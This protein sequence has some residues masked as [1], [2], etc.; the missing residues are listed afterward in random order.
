[1]HSDILEINIKYEDIKHL[2][3]LKINLIYHD[4]YHDIYHRILLSR[5]SDFLQRLNHTGIFEKI[6]SKEMQRK[7]LE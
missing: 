4:I 6:Y 2:D 1:M 3:I 5:A 7:I